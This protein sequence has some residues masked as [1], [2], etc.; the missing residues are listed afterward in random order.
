MKTVRVEL[1]CKNCG[2][3]FV[4]D[5]DDEMYDNDYDVICQG[6]SQEQS[7]SSYDYYPLN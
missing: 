6:C 1:T 3:R 5:V 2:Y 4:I 7:L